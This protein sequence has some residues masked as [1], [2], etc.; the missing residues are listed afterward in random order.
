MAAPEHPVPPP[1]IPT[2]PY[3]QTGVSGDL[4]IRPIG[5]LTIDILPQTGRMPQFL[6]RNESTEGQLGKNEFH[7][8]LLDYSYRWEST[9]FYCNPLY[10]EQ[11][12][13]ERYGYHWGILQPFV[14]GA[15]FFVKIPLMPYGLANHHWREP[16]YSLG[17]YRP[18]SYA[19]YQINWPEVRIWPAFVEGGFITAL[20]YLIP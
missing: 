18:G 20:V 3:P 11:P 8:D 15:Q 2:A 12:N 5:A 4:A 9:A 6:D 10:F 13:L 19:P 17:Y 16:I 1:T 7:R 14:S